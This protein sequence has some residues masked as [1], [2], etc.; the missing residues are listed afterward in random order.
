[1]H[2]AHSTPAFEKKTSPSIPGRGSEDSSCSLIMDLPPFV[3][4][5]KEAV[6]PASS[7]FSKS[8]KIFLSS[9]FILNPDFWI[10]EMGRG[11][12]RHVLSLSM[13][14]HQ[15]KQTAKTNKS[16]FTSLR[17]I[18]AVTLSWEK[19]IK[20]DNFKHSLSF[21]H[22][23]LPV[24]QEDRAHCVHIVECC[25]HASTVRLGGFFLVLNSF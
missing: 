25:V 23:L 8:L 9:A 3:K 10:K 16:F 7:N 15:L 12:H 21:Q 1:M 22:F 4:R 2:Y 24:E 17:H 11:S 18:F 14:L 19:L 20:I 6:L 13:Q 5:V